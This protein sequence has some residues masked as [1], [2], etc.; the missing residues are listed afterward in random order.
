VLGIPTP[1]TAER[2]YEETDLNRGRAGL[3]VFLSD[4]VG[5][6]D[7]QGKREDWG[8]SEQGFGTLDGQ[9]KHLGFTYNSYTPYAPLLMDLTDGP[10]VVELPAGPLICIAM[11]VNQLWVADLGLPGP[12]AGKGDKAVFLPPG[13]KDEAPAGYRVANSSSNTM[14]VGIR[15]LPVNGDVA[16]AMERID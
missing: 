1:E 15:S 8:S 9:P 10:M 12:A 14:L 5:L 13:Y 7:L 4:G 16:G 2:V 6:C 11:D 3:L